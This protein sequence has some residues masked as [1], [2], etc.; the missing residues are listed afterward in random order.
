MLK[1]AKKISYEWMI[2]GCLRELVPHVKPFALEAD[3]VVYNVEDEAIILWQIVEK[4]CYNLH[5]D[6]FMTATATTTV[7]SPTASPDF[8]FGFGPKFKV[9]CRDVRARRL[10]RGPGE[11]HIQT[12]SQ[13]VTHASSTFF[14]N[15][16]KRASKCTMHVLHM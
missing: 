2:F 15:L 6:E 5:V 1:S 12:C 3:N 7:V 9:V 14:S 13:T 16:K 8:L 10:G 11:M 4:I